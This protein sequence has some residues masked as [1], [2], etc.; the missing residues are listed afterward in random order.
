MGNL[1]PAISDL[2]RALPIS[3]FQLPISPSCESS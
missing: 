3:D 1:K 2:S